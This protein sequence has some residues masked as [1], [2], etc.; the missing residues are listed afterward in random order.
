MELRGLKKK[1]FKTISELEWYFRRSFKFPTNWANPKDQR[2]EFL[3]RIAE[4]VF[5]YVFVQS[6][7]TG[8]FVK[9]EVFWGGLHLMDA[10]FDGLDELPCTFEDAAAAA[11]S[12]AGAFLYEC[13]CGD[14]QYW[15]VD[16]SEFAH[17]EPNN[18]KI[19]TID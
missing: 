18:Y 2:R 15:W 13:E 17:Q 12:Q 3:V 6:S 14:A 7:S 4:D 1:S 19:L 8:Q 9:A 16:G 11:L 10:D 5:K